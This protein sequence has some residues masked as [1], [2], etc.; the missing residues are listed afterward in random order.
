ME[1]ASKTCALCGCDCTCRPRVK[2]AKGRYYCRECYDNA[3]Q[4]ARR[5]SAAARYSVGAADRAVRRAPHEPVDAL[6]G[7]LQA[8][9]AEPPASKPIACPGC[10]ATTGG[11]VICLACGYDIRTGKRLGMPVAGAKAA[12]RAAGV[13][14]SV[15]AVGARALRGTAEFGKPI[16][17]GIAGGAMGAIVWA[18]VACGLGLQ[19]G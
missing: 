7:L 12:E 11:G 1:N 9:R 19:L 2:D 4:K 16:L 18:V 13:A 3:N 14:E 8:E 6:Q 15:A 17:F 10:G 5:P